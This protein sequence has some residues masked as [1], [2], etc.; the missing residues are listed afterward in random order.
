[1]TAP[2]SVISISELNRLTRQTLEQ[3]FPLLWVTGEISNLIRATS[4]HV[5]FTLKD[6]AAQARCVMFRTRA[7]IIPWRLENGQ[8]VEAR[9]LVSLYE[10][11]GDFQLNIETMRRAGLGRL[12]EEFSRLKQQL[13]MEGLFAA[14][15]KKSLPRLP[16][17]IGIISSPQ[18]AALQDVL[19]TLNRRAPH[20]AIV[21]YP[22]LVQGEMAA[23]GIAQ[24]IIS[25][26]HRNECDLLLLVRGGGSIE[27]LWA[28]NEEIVAYAIA[29]STLPIIS[30]VGHETDTTI[31]DFVADLRAP[32]PTAAAELATQNWHGMPQKIIDLSQK[33]NSAMQYRISRDQQRLDHIALRLT[34]PAN[35]LKRR[36]DQMH[37]LG[38][39]INTA[40]TSYL[41]IRHE[42]ISRLAMRFNRLAPRVESRQG[43]LAL[44]EQ[45]LAATKNRFFLQARSALDTLSK[46]LE[47]LNPHDTLAR[48]FAIVRNEQGEV[49]S[50]ASG[51]QTGNQIAVELATGHVTA[52]VL[53]TSSSE[54]RLKKH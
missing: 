45:R 41:R 9:A 20:L 47:H 48:G 37:L 11:R 14:E 3:V 13:E 40:L 26:G 33:L 25:A 8:Q 7:Q 51:L 38:S 46:A 39:Q 4:G 52:K 5:Y 54:E 15:R 1:M 35:N 43:E 23:K 30:G 17:R 28:F 29:R 50:H 6:N 24:A 19:S 42:H 53:T 32:T 18:A 49:V 12:F 27:D 16:N 22:T 34:H 44:L 21:L 31:A 36:Q 10:P 2:T